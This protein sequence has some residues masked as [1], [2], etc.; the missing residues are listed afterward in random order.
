MNRA[1]LR[2]DIMLI[3]LAT[4]WGSGFVAQRAAMDSMGPYTFT[5]LRFAIGTIILLPVLIARHRKTLKNGANKNRANRPVRA[6]ADT[7]LLVRSALLG[8]VLLGVLMAA[9]ASVQ[10]VGMVSTTA[11]RGGFITG[12]Y[13]LFV[14]AFGLLLRQRAGVGHVLGAGL[15]AGGLW[16]LSGDLSGGIHLGDMLILLCAVLWALHVVLLGVLAPRSDPIGLAAV[17]FVVVAVLVGVLAILFERDSM[18]TLVH[19]LV[20]LLYSGIFAIGIAFTLQIF[21]QQHAPAAHAAVLMSL[22][23]VFAAIFGTLLLGERLTK[24]EILGCALMFSGMLISQLWPHKRTR[25]ELD[26]F[27]DPVR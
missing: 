14:P 11:S 25:A 18:G 12:L 5:A 24:T 8:G 9:A 26:E 15:A 16:L 19:G 3:I 6:Q 13:V 23:A 2:A 20:P 10:Q 7:N 4:I 17:Q 22:E 27:K 21:A 1:A